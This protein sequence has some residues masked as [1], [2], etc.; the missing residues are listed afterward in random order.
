MH[1]QNPKV[2]GIATEM[3]LREGHSFDFVLLQH[4]G[5]TTADQQRMEKTQQQFGIFAN[6][7]KTGFDESEYHTSLELQSD[8]Y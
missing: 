3:K 6:P 2:I 5:W 7:K 1:S 4:E 8:K